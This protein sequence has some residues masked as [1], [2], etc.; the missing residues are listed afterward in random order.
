MPTKVL[1]TYA[2]RSGSTAE[3][4]EAIA[5]TL[6]EEHATADCIHV[7]DVTTL[8]GYDLVVMGAPLYI[9]NWPK[10]AHQFLNRLKAALLTKA[11]VIFALG[12]TDVEEK[13]MA[14]AE[15][16]LTTVFAKY[17]WLH[18]I[19]Q[20]MFVGRFDP[21]KMTGWHRWLMKLPAMKRIPVQ[22]ARDW[23]GIKAWSRE[24][25]ALVPQ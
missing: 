5:A 6:R 23:D 25:V 9:G 16:Q 11:V 22:D 15:Q 21:T 10:E 17:E 14:E 8:D 13:S 7:D 1:V 18:P 24:L 20:K 4:A 3:V 2:S 19:A 12:P